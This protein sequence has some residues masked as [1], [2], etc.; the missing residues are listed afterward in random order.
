[1]SIFDY[2]LSKKI[3][4]IRSLEN[5]LK[6][7][8]KELE[9]LGVLPKYIAEKWDKLFEEQFKSTEL[10]HLINSFVFADMSI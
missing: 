9:E 1:M 10:S 7:T 5:K 8:E 4:Q 3:K 2:F 6:R